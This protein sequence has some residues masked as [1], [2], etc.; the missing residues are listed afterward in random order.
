MDSP[1]VRA[2]RTRGPDP[3]H[4]PVREEDAA[5]HVRGV[6]FKTGPPLRTGVEL[7]WLVRDR[8]KREAVVPPGRLAEALAPLRGPGGLPHGGVLTSEPGGQLEL[9]CPPASS[10]AGCVAAAAGDLTALRRALA[11]AGLVLDGAGLD[12]WREP[13][14]VLDHP[15]Y[16][17]M[18][19]YFDRYGPWGRVMMRATAAVQV[20][21]DAGDESDGVTGFRFRWR[22]AH[23]LGPVLVAAFANSPV[24]RGRPTGWASTRQAVWARLD[25][26]RTRQPPGGWRSPRRDW[27]RYALDAQVMCVRP[28]AS[29]PWRVPPGLAL[30]TWLGG[31]PAAGRAPTLTDVDYH[32]TTLFPPVRPR[33]HLELR[34]VDAQPGDGWIVP[35]LVVS[36]LL[37]D[38]VAAALAHEAT[39]PLTDD[40]GVPPW[41]V[42][43]RAARTG[44]RGPG[45]GTAVRACLRAAL[46]ALARQRVP[47]PLVDAVAGFLDRYPLRGRCPADDQLD[48]LRDGGPHRPVHPLH[49]PEGNPL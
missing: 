23:R 41:E 24:H 46:D 29:G 16:R 5:T 34:M 43:L 10:P 31:G 3:A 7:E 14:R 20:C 47:A 19:T 32:L 44:P 1:A 12:P 15:R 26:Q 49:L 30:R 35:V 13:P 25:P 45:L 37:D 17:A 28:R 6:C 11:P 18:E 38:P 36:A 39:R 4:R 8:R 33:G 40:R 2:E 27:A 9:S 42:W 48:A 21:V 22:L